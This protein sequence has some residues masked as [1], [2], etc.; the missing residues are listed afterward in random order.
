MK[1]F[2][3]I[4]VGSEKYPALTGI[5][6][7]GATVVFF[8][9]FPF[10]GNT[11]ITINVLAFF[12]VLSGFLITR[13]YY[14][15]IEFT[16][17][18]WRKYFVN[19]FARIYP[20][21]FLLLTVAILLRH[22]F[23]P[24]LLLKNYT[25]THALFPNYK[26]YIIEPSWSL[27]VEECFYFLAPF[28]MLIIRKINFLTS[29]FFGGIL[30][31]SA[32]IISKTSTPFLHTPLFVF[33]T[34]F[35]G[36]FAEFFAGIYLAL[37]VMR[38][39]VKGAIHLNGFRFTVIGAAGVAILIVAM[40]LVYSQPTLQQSY[41][42]LINNFLI[43]VPIAIL[44]YGFICENTA[45]S[46]FLSGK[47]IGLIGRGSYTFYLLHTIIIMYVSVPFIIPHLGR[48]YL[49]SALVTYLLSYLI[50]IGIFALYEEPLNIFIRKKYLAKD[51]N[52]VGSASSK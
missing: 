31:A 51:K 1:V 45:A 26:D 34:T 23:R 42:I 50:S 35:F 39:E 18:G 33:T 29:V 22:D 14:G 27:T 44:Y 32:L 2:S 10:P 38:K 3:G 46:R 52:A 9:H 17:T 36:H 24:L 48:Q 20:V 21:Y 49:V 7:V 28:I 11:H 30:L 5:R 12:F 8:D 4:K 6:A 41:I 25:L 13:I 43:P 47:L 19:R 15:K 40:T 37:V 16:R